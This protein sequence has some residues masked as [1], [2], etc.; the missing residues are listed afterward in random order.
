MT[1]MIIVALARLWFQTD[2][3]VKGSWKAVFDNDQVNGGRW[4]LNFPSGSMIARCI[5]EV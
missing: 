5:Q 4:K 1:R 2:V 3:E